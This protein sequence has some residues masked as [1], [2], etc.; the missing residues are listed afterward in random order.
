VL[1]DI[2]AD[3]SAVEGDIRMGVAGALVGVLLLAVVWNRRERGPKVFVLLF[4][5]GWTALSIRNGL[6]DGEGHRRAVQTLEHGKTERVE[7]RVEKLVGTPD[8][9]SLEVAGH[10]FAVGGGTALGLNRTSTNGGPLRKGESVRITF[11]G[12]S[13]L[14][15]E[16]VAPAPTP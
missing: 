5:A 6:A 9:E 3:R 2:R 10:V 15:V 16:A 14:L 8:G 13:I 1:Y 4:L 7:G 11:S 12:K